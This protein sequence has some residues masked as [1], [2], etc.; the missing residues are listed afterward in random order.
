MSFEFMHDILV[1]LSKIIRQNA[2]DVAI[3]QE[4]KHKIY[5]ECIKINY[6]LNIIIG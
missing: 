5:T 2:Y 4:L 1:Y 3:K 6:L